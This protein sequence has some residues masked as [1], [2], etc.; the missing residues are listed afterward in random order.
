MG[1]HEVVNP[2]TGDASRLPK[3]ITPVGSSLSR[4]GQRSRRGRYQEEAA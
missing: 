2:F 3:E 4:V 1:E